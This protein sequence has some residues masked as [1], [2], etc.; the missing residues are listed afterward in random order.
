[1]SAMPSSRY[2]FGTLPWYSVL[3]VCGIT[4][5]LWLANREE[6]RL[7]LPKDTVIDLSLW[8]IP[9]GII[10]ARLYYVFFAWDAFSRDP[11]SILYIWRG[12]LAIYGGVIGGGVAALIFSRRRKL[13][14][15]LLTDV[16]VPG[17]ALAQCIGRWG[18]Y[19]NMEAYGLT[20]TDPAWQLF[21]FAVLI[22]SSGEPVW[23]MATF[24]YESVWD[25]LVFLVLM[26]GRRHMRRIGDATLWYASLYGGGRL[27]IEGLRLDSLMTTGGSARI[28]QLLSVVLC[29]AVFIIFALRALRLPS[30]REW[31]CGS[32]ALAASAALL[33]FLPAPDEA[34]FGYHALWSIQL[35]CV[36]SALAMIAVKT[37]VSLRRRISL[38]CPLAAVAASVIL[39][40]YLSSGAYSGVEASALL[41]AMFTLTSITSTAAIYPPLTGADSPARSSSL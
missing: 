1:M 21:P 31:L 26:A 18:N 39:R 6:K 4:A 27:I 3:I 28:S 12:G 40:V 8:L 33:I 15:L 29:L 5:A 34:F 2:I 32:V 10:G 17:L 13:P 22:P 19:F 23:H 16:I 30:K 14:F 41:C 25:F 38:L 9:T 36:S 37:G 24:F 20:V 11:I 35:L 7:K